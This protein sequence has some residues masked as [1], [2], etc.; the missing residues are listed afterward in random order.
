VLTKDLKLATSVFLILV[1]T[2]F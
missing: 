1:H 2:Q